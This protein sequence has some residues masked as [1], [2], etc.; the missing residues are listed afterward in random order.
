MPS[1][2]SYRARWVSYVLPTLLFIGVAIAALLL[3]RGYSFDL[4]SGLKKTGLIVLDT[5]PKNAYITVNNN[6]ER[7]RTRATLKLPAGEYDVKVDLP[8]VHPWQKRIR[9]EPGQ[10]ELEEHILLFKR[11]PESTELTLG[12]PASQALSASG[13]QLAYLTGTADGAALSSVRIKS[14]GIEPAKNIVTLPAAYATPR[15]LSWSPDESRIIAS[16]GNET[17]I[18]T[19]GGR[20]TLMPAGGRAALAPGQTDVAIVEPEPGRL[21]RATG[22]SATSST[23]AVE[24]YESDVTAWTPA[25][26]ALYVARADGT[27]VRRGNG[28]DRRVISRQ[29]VLTDLSAAAEDTEQVFARDA[30]R[31][32]YRI[33]DKG[34]EQLATDVDRYTVSRDGNQVAYLKQRELRLWDRL[35]ET[36]DLLTRFTE[37]P[38]Q[39][40]V[41]PGG[42]YVLYSRGGGLHVIAADGTNDVTLAPGVDLASVINREQVLVRSQASGRSTALTILNQ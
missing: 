13:H 27:L 34:L 21:V 2:P 3:V 35:R 18:I 8:D 24:P 19:D 32:L 14:D 6:V 25:G 16:A 10:A 22:T 37:A 31:T 41:V 42:Y 7:E 20:T 12:A 29:P 4:T 28:T 9:L 40:A 26:R 5:N 11:Q 15:S 39:L 23:G 30:S 33:T 1:K 17:R 38:E 36:D